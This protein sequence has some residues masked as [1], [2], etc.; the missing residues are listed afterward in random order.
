MNT[1]VEWVKGS[2]IEVDP[3]DDIL[4]VGDFNACAFF[5][6]KSE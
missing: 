5:L 6:T 1:L 2:D 4:L 3:D